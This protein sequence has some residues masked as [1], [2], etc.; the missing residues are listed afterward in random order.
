MGLCRRLSVLSLPQQCPA[1]T[2]GRLRHDDHTNRAK[3]AATIAVA[4]TARKACTRADAICEPARPSCHARP[5]GHPRRQG[6]ACCG[7]RCEARPSPR[8]LRGAFTLARSG[9]PSNA[10]AGA[11]SWWCVAA[12]RRTRP[13]RPAAAADGRSGRRGWPWA[14]LRCAGPGHAEPGLRPALLRSW[15]VL[16]GDTRSV[17]SPSGC[18]GGWACRT[19]PKRACATTRSRRPTWGS[20]ATTTRFPTCRPRR[21]GHGATGSSTSWPGASSWKRT[22]RTSTAGSCSQPCVMMRHAGWPWPTRASRNLASRPCP[23]VGRR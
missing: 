8:S 5:V 4:P 22:W 15:A 20:A 17:G 23:W 1:A 9:S 6:P 18:P 12:W 7:R 14:V 3:P 13:R 21:S 16:H 2:A 19:W 11:H 10:V